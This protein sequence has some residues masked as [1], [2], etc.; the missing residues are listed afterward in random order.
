[1]SLEIGLRLKEARESLGLSIQ[2]IRDQTRIE[3]GY[4]IALENG[5]FDKLPSPYFVRTC[6]RAYAK[7][8]GIEPHHLLK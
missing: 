3:S 5:E 4:L 8:V 6:I 7:C 2:D 1:M